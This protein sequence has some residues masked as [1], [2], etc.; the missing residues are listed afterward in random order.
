MVQ[1]AN[2]STALRQCFIAVLGSISLLVIYYGLFPF[3]SARSMYNDILEDSW[4][5][6]VYDSPKPVSLHIQICPNVVAKSEYAVVSMLTILDE[7]NVVK[8]LKGLSKLAHA[9][10][11]FSSL[12][13]LVLIIDPSNNNGSTPVL[14]GHWQPCRLPAIEG[15]ASTPPG[16]ISSNRFLFTK[17]YSKLWIW[18]L[19]EY[20]AVLYIDADTLLIRQFSGIFTHELPRMVDRGFTVAMGSNDL[21]KSDDF[22]AGVM[23]VLP[24]P[25]EFRNLISNISFLRHDVGLAEQNYLNEF[26]R[27]RIH[28]LPFRY[29]GMVSRKTEHPLIWKRSEPNMVILHFTCKP[30]NYLNCLK[31]GIQDLC[32]LWHWI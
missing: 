10:Q 13:A 6:R 20:R 9:I 28:T 25:K 5:V 32:L 23:L 17:M 4:I 14:P 1:S 30:W 16:V 11:H 27:G 29:N 24:S 8:Y 3:L 26:Y 31:D 2:Q 12:D 21:T 22:N 19:S 18:H 7:A 15:P